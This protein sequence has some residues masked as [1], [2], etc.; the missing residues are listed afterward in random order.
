MPFPSWLPVLLGFLTAVGPISTDMYLPAF[1]ALESDLGAPV[2]SA[3]ITLATWFCGLAVGQITQ[4]TL[5]DRFGR[6]AP[7]LVGTMLYT[8]GSAA[9]ALSPNLFWLSAFRAVTAIGA[10]ASMVIPRAMVRDLSDGLA[11]AR[12]MSK[13]MLV[14]GVAPILAPS[15]GSAV[16]G[17]ASWRAIFWFA[18]GYGV[19]AAV[20]VGTL[21]PETLPAQHRV[22]LGVAGLVQRYAYIARERV[23]LTH[24][25][26]GGAAFFGMFA[27]IGGS[28]PVFIDGLGLSPARYAL[29]FSTCAA[30]FIAA[31]QVNARILPRFGMFRVIRAA[32]RLY[33]CAAAALAAVAFSGHA[34]AVALIVPLA[35]AMTSLGFLMPNTTVGALSRHAAHA[36]SASALM[37]TMQ[38]AM[39]A[40]SGVAVGWLTDGTPR[41]MAALMLLGATATVLV[42]LCRPRP[43]PSGP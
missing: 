1:P 32:S 16:L 30:G 20:V 3:Q 41:G 39:G 5:S 6:R 2:G 43:Q 17:I 21:L 18:T 38:F 28:S 9:C 19:L 37:G 10:S 11:A 35:A 33:W 24:A 15:L 12:L 8:L 25:V 23:F 42:D 14:M 36:A 31:S 40:V 34:G 4:G 7:L 27:Y 29:V 26:M 13:L 22:R